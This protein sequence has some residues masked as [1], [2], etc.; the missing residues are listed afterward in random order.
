MK[1]KMTTILF[2]ILSIPILIAATTI[3]MPPMIP[4]IDNKDKAPLQQNN[5]LPKVCDLIPPMVLFLPPPM[6]TAMSECK[7]KLGMPNKEFTEAQLSKLFKK[8]IKVKSIEIVEKFNQL[9]KVKYNGGVILV[10][11]DV[12]AFIKQ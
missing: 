3:N 10:N 8:D 5:S 11:K 4:T 9:Y 6:Q 7:N 1:N 2:C 12:N